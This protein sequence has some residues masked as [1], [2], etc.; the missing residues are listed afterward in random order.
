MWFP[1]SGMGRAKKLFIQMEMSFIT[2]RNK[3]P[4]VPN[5]NTFRPLIL[6][7]VIFMPII[8]LSSNEDHASL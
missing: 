4:Q 5:R 8:F 3:F 1:T 2:L 6:P 7:P